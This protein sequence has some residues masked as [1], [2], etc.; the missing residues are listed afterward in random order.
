MTKDNSN[1]IIYVVVGSLLAIF[2]VQGFLVAD[3]FKTTKNALVRESNAILQDAFKRD[4][5]IRE[6]RYHEKM[7]NL[8]IKER[9]EKYDFSKQDPKVFNTIDILS[10]VMNISVSSTC[11][12]TLQNFDSITNSVLQSRGIH[13]S[14]YVEL[15][16]NLKNKTQITR[17]KNTKTILSFLEI[18]SQPLTINIQPRQTLTLVLENPLDIILQRMALMLISS[19]A[20]SILCF[21]AY[22]RL[23]KMLAKQKQLVKFKNDFLSTIAHELKR[24][25]GTLTFNLD[26]LLIPAFRANDEKYNNTVKHSL[27]A[28]TELNSTIQMIVALAR[29]EE[30]LLQLDTQPTDVYALIETLAEK[31]EVQSHKPTAISLHSSAQTTEIMA[32]QQLLSQCFANL[33]D[34]AIKYSGTDVKINIRLEQTAK[35]IIVSVADNG[36]GIPADKLSAIFDK[37]SRVDQSVKVNGFG[38]GLNYVKT[39]VEMHKG[40]VRVESEWEKG[41]V[42][43]IKL[44]LRR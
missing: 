23:M 34:N 33:I 5:N 21:V 2:I 1:R 3:Y 22:G 7:I 39:I 18:R 25:V 28:T 27:E 30:G 6:N 12:L 13:S 17:S 44:P 35:W 10:I 32:D 24:P 29:A 37:Y 31:F 41:S 19:I 14:F 8:E 36:I 26:C 40:E 16:S 43:T 9:N 20:F 15:C 42:F 4:L 38:I 11:P